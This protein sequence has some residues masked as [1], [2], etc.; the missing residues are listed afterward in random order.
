MG[1]Y[2][3]LE[4]Q[5]T[6]QGASMEFV[7]EFASD[8]LAGLS[9][10][11]KF[12][13]FKYLYDKEG[14]NLFEQICDQPEYYP[15]RTEAAIMQKYSSQISE[16]VVENNS[17]DDDY[18]A[19]A[20][21]GIIGDHDDDRIDDN[22]SGSCS[23]V[24]VIELGSGSSTKTRILLTEILAKTKNVCYFP[25]DI[26]S[27]IL[28]ETESNLSL[29]F[30]QLYV[31]GIPADYSHGIRRVNRIISEGYNNNNNNETAIPQRKLVLFLGSSIGNFEPPESVSFFKMLRR[32]ITETTNDMLLVGFD[33]VKDKDVLNAAYNDEK[34][35][36]AKFNLNLLNRINI[37]LNGE[38]DLDKFE[39]KALYNER[40]KRV[41]MYLT[42][43]VDQNVYI[44]KLNRSFAFKRGE[45]IHTENSYKYDISQ[46]AD[47]ASKSGFA[48]RKCFMDD[49]NWFCLAL[50]QPI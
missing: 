42:S 27:N 2:M 25:I 26:S 28:R 36:T 4:Q 37:E 18:R 29:E 16:L 8:V 45:E 13:H 9:S 20:I 6:D 40:L 41:E 11:K 34:G 23:G 49:K 19:P 38:F 44:A 47:I 1:K 24:S 17:K 7:Q 21:D 3:T 22:S 15:T 33:L 35:I 12:L 46:I 43:K 48:L 10:A 50:F 39:H 5:R 30:P 14:S 31:Q 32:E